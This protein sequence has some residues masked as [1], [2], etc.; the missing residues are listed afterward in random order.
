MFTE[1]E[2]KEY[3][4]EIRLE[5]CS[6]CIER[7]PDGPPCAPLGKECGIEMHLPELIAVIREVKSPLI[8]PYLENTR[9]KICAHCDCLHSSVC[10]CSMDYLAVLLVD[11]VERVDERR[12]QRQ[13][14]PETLVG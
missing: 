14:V 4:D 2:S 10:P 7:P 3:L 1:A 13:E 8:A 11:A 12:R 5:V 6:R 9:Q